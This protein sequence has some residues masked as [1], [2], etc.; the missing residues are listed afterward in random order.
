M[1]AKLVLATP[2][3]I[4]PLNTDAYKWLDTLPEGLFRSP[5]EAKAAVI[6]F[7]LN[8][9]GFTMYDKRATYKDGAR[10]YYGNKK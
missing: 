6:E 3:Q 2:D 4:R 9:K 1:T 10:Q 7:Q 8:Q 5:A